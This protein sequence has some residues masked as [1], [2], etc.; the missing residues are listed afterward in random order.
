MSGRV[1]LCV[2][3]LTYKMLIPRMSDITVTIESL[4]FVVSFKK[5]KNMLT[6]FFRINMPYGIARNE[7]GEWMAFNREYLPLGYNSTTYKGI[8]GVDY[9]DLPIYTSYNRITDSQ[10]IALAGENTIDRN[11][12]GEIVRIF[13]YDDATN[14]RNRVLGT[15]DLWD[16]YFKK[17]RKLSGYQVNVRGRMQ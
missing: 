12:A 7:K 3:W 6:D 14:P 16:A 9:Q 2:F 11:E 17:I 5:K 15:K 13:L 1:I 10:L 8:P 4:L